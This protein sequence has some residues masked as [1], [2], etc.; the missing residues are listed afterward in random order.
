MQVFSI[1]SSCLGTN[2][3]TLVEYAEQALSEKITTGFWTA[4]K[5]FFPKK[6]F[7]KMMQA[8]NDSCCLLLPSQSNP[9]KKP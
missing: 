8:K 7:L 6:V 1:F 4:R 3:D 2:P 9:W 5:K